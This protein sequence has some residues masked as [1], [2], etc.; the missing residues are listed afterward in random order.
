MSAN[1]GRQ[2]ASPPEMQ[3]PDSGAEQTGQAPDYEELICSPWIGL[4]YRTVEGIRV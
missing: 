4:H 3:K 2:T 1:T